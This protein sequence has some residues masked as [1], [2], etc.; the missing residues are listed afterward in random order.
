MLNEPSAAL[1]DELKAALGPSGWRAPEDAPAFFEE[2]RGRGRGAAALVLRPASTEEVAEAVRLCARARVGVVP[3]GGGTG[4]VGGQLSD[5]TPRPVVLSLDRMARIRQ[6]APEAE[7][8]E[9][10]AGA[11][12]ADVR[13]AAERA[14]RLFPLMLASW[15]S[16]RIGGL[17]AT[18]A[19]GLNVL[20]Y[21]V[22]RDLVLGVEAVLPDGTVL[23]DLKTLRKDNT[24][25]DVGRLLIGA[26]GALGV[27]TA[28]TLKL[29][30]RPAESAT[31]FCAVPSPAAAAALL[32]RLRGALAEMVSAF[33]LI[34]GVVAG[35]LEEAL[36]ADAP[37]VPLKARWLA[38]A[39]VEGGA[40]S[41]VGAALEA[42][43]ADALE[44][45]EVEDAA[46]AQSEA[47]RAAFWR[48]REEI[49]EA[50]RRIGAVAS[51]DVSLPLDRIPEFVERGRAAVA[52]IEPR[53]RVAAFG[54]LGD[55]NLH[56]NM[57]PPERTPAS[58]FRACAPALTRATHDLTHEMGG[59]I[60]AEHGI[61]RL[62][63]ADL[64][65][66]GDPGKLA[67]MRAIKRALDPLGIMNPG[68][69][70]QAV[71]SAPPE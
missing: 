23:R 27:I 38:L 41:G 16:A 5:A 71:P 12:L 64:V 47:Q 18:N 59:S 45:G 52:A 56:Y 68:A 51:H 70:L 57:F 3:Y 29:F 42:A 10:E 55:G 11:I 20:R 2:P 61:G 17:L 48:V 22:A 40:G 49:P 14:D 43:L 19:G 60:S 50:N 67:A 13:A 28:A 9:A 63:A 53:L 7:A 32:R 21:G 26:E 35:F 34:D 15:G 33:E 46:L 31:A 25:F 58:A 54:H 66:Y 6:V 36:G 65:R 37:P 1:L 24:G 30:P 8:M 4:L 62:K 44:A 69:V 39:E